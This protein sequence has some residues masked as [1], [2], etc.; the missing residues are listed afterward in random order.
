VKTTFRF[1]LVIAA[2]AAS[3]LSV[4]N[5]VRAEKADPGSNPRS[6]F[7]NVFLSRMLGANAGSSAVETQ[8]PDVSETPQAGEDNQGQNV[9]SGTPDVSGTSGVSNDSQ[10]QNEPTE[11][12]EAPGTESH[13]EVTGTVTAVDASTIT[14]DGVVYNL[15]NFSEVKGTPQVG[16]SVK[17]DFVTNPDGTLSISEVKTG[18]QGDNSGGSLNSGDGS[19]SSNGSG[20]S[21]SGGKDSSGGSGGNS[22]NGG[23]GH[24]GGGS[25]SSGGSGGGGDG[26]SGG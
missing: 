24:D 10:G 15:T 4:W 17:L 18:Q 21:S 3:A 23:G 16:D 12:T 20:S 1:I 6:I 14:V 25:G 8:T 9:Q 13:G 11:A 7:N 19:G 2:V 26:G 22:N 5:G